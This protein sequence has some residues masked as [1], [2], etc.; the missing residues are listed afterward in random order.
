[1]LLINDIKEFKLINELIWIVKDITFEH[2]D[3]PRHIPYELPAYVIV[4]LKESSF[5]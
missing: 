4:E 2:K 5:A 1:M 3:G